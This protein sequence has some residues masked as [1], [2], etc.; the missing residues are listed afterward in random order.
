MENN[1]L[2]HIEGASVAYDS[3]V[4]LQDVTLTIYDH[5]FLG[6]IGPNGGG[7]T[8]LVKLI[9]GIMQ[10]QHGT[11]TYYDTNNQPT[12]KI[13]IGYLPQYTSFDFRFPITV[14]EVVMAGMLAGKSMTYRFTAAD[15][16]RTQ[17]VLQLLELD[18]LA[19]RPIGELSGGQRQRVLMARALTTQPRLLVLDEPSTYIDRN[20]ENHIYSLLQS[21]NE[22][23]AIVLVSHDMGAVIQTVR[24][25]ACVNGTVHYHPATEPADHWFEHEM[26]CPLELV[27]HGHVPHRV[28]TSH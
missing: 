3:T 14:E 24:N 25:I 28:L 21:L 2:I 7:K 11:V 17:E 6:V 4:A 12:H 20:S 19:R 16:Q 18:S 13:P 27:A 8:T 22:Q 15:R 1:R 5:D 10:P 9:L 23:C 26:G